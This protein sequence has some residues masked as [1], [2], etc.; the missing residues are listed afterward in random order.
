VALENPVALNALLSGLTAACEVTQWQTLRVLANFLHCKSQRQALMHSPGLAG[1]LFPALFELLKS[2]NEAVVQ[3]ATFVACNL[4]ANHAPAPDF[5]YNTSLMRVLV[6]TIQHSREDMTVLYSS[7]ALGNL[8]VDEQTARAALTYCASCN[9]LPHVVQRFGLAAQHEQWVQW[10]VN[11]CRNFLQCGSKQ[12]HELLHKADL[13]F[14]L[15]SLLKS[16]HEF[17]DSEEA[18]KSV[19]N[20][21]AF[22]AHE[23]AAIA[24]Q[25]ARSGCVPRLVELLGRYESTDFYVSQALSCLYVHS[26]YAQQDMQQRAIFSAMVRIFRTTRKGSVQ[27]KLAMVLLNFN[28]ADLERHGLSRGVM[29]QAVSNF[30]GSSLTPA[31]MSLADNI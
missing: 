29:R 21:I 28:D 8:I 24:D 6:H 30:K 20:C 18:V 10:V 25:C 16:H 26:S 23:S 13:G 14:A 5:E 2:A 27:A 7:A 9:A 31:R 3:K 11:L 1:R 17:L 19:V 15:S 22:A 4:R 12:A